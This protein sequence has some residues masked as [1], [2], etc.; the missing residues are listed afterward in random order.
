MS[1]ATIPTTVVIVASRPSGRGHDAGVV[2]CVPVSWISAPVVAGVAPITTV[3]VLEL[4]ASSLGSRQAIRD[5]VGEA[6]R[7]RPSLCAV[8]VR[9]EPLRQRD[10]LAEAGIRIAIVDAVSG[11][12]RG[13]RRPAPR[14]WPC[15]SLVWG[16]WEVQAAPVVRGWRRMMRGTTLPITRAGGLVVAHADDG[17]HRLEDCLAWAAR[18]RARGSATTVS[19]N[20]LPALIEQG[21]ASC[22][23]DARSGSILRAA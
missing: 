21:G 1:R 9:G 17:G 18:A 14:G 13:T 6:R 11:E 4:P 5:L 8:R 3:D 12:T 10:V 7:L 22:D 23:P 20:D 16:L 15:R 2:G 19:V